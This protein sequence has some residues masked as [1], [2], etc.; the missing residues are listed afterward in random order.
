MDFTDNSHQVIKNY[1][2]FQISN[3]FTM[4]LIVVFIGLNLQGQELNTYFS[5]E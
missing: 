4:H 5:L 1:W 3:G 2:V